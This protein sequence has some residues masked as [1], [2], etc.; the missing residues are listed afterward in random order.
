MVMTVG[1]LSRRTGVPV[2]TLR[3]YEDMGLIYT[4]GRSA[5]NYRLFDEDALWC[6]GLIGSLRGLGLTVAEI[7]GLAEIY[8][9]QSQEPIGPRLAELLHAVRARTDDRISD[10]TDL[11]RRIDDFEADHG[12]EL[13]GLAD[14]RDQDPRSGN[15]LDSPPGVRP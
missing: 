9:G 14:F 4:V 2:K 7:R 13:A 1:G 11:L 5:G 3:E 6:V 15:P 12:A 10:L 8:L